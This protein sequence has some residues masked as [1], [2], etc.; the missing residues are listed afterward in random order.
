MTEKQVTT[1]GHSQAEPQPPPHHHRDR[2]ACG[3]GNRRG[4][5]LS[6]REAEVN[7]AHPRGFQATR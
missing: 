2:L 7:T 3:M 1:A 6:Q 4:T 5:P